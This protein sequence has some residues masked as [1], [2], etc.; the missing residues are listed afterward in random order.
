MWLYFIPSHA[1]PPT[2]SGQKANPQGL[3]IFPLCYDWLVIYCHI[4]IAM[5]TRSGVI[6]GAVFG[7]LVGVVL[8]LIVIATVAFVIHR[9]RHRKRTGMTCFMQKS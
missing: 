5:S 2:A 8:T 6:V 7:A 3:L 4:I 9:C 1:E